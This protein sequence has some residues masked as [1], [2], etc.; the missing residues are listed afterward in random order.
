MR[1]DNPMND[2]VLAWRADIIRRLAT[3][4]DGR[5]EIVADDDDATVI[6]ITDV[7]PGR[8]AEMAV[9]V[10]GDAEDLMYAELDRR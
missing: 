7:G 4:L 8:F 6:T 5:V 10:D 9:W 1:R 3:M 2:A